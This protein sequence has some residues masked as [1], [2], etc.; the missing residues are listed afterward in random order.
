MNT[1]QTTQKTGTNLKINI[2]DVS[3]CYDDIGVGVIPIIFIHGF[4]FDRSCWEPQLELFAKTQR[5][6]TYDIRGFGKSGRGKE[7]MSI[8]LFADDL[9][10]FMDALEIDKAIV[11]GLSM[12]GYIL[13]DAVSRY[14][15]RFD[16]IILS[17]TQCVSD[18]PDI[19]EKRIQAIDEINEHGLKRFAE[20]FLKKVFHSETYD[21][22]KSLVEKIRTLIFSNSTNSITGTLKAIAERN[23]TC[24][25]LIKISIPTLIICG[26]GDNIIP[27]VQS[28]FL[29]R[30]ITQ[31]KLH[32]IDKAGHLCNLEQPDQFN[33]L[34]SDFISGLT[35]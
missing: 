10:Q 26:A 13:L 15:D 16:A 21:T 30:T 32:M 1:L 19:K 27:P 20:D 8:H 25:S 29:H 12:G 6:I 23:E 9:I 5:V 18:T 4:P 22:N 28:E 31:S 33:R 14:H 34:V 24:S 7:D 11:C 3:F 35:K 17:G 2:K